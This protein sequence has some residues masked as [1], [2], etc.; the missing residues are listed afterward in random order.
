M[1]Y[2]FFTTNILVELAIIPQSSY[3]LNIM[4]SISAHGGWV[5]LHEAQAPSPYSWCQA[6]LLP[7]CQENLGRALQ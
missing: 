1:V 5:R 7:W 2:K 3:V 6:L 4:I